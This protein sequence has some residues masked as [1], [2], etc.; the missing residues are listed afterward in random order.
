MAT[1]FVAFKSQVLYCRFFL[2]IPHIRSILQASFS[3][4]NGRVCSDACCCKLCLH[5]SLIC[6]GELKSPL[7]YSEGDWDETMGVNLK[8]PWLLMKAVGQQMRQAG[9]GGSIIFVSSISGIER[10]FYP[11]VSVHGAAMAALHQLTKVFRVICAS[12][13]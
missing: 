7:E 1:V 4:H 11:G 5:R 13:V 12:M 6:E 10:G 8:T 9:R 2:R 3:I